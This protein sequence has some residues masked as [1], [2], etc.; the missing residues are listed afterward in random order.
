MSESREPDDGES[1]PGTAKEPEQEAP[2]GEAAPS[3]APPQSTPTTVASAKSPGRKSALRATKHTSTKKRLKLFLFGT[4]GVGKTTAAICFPRSY[5]I[6]A[7]RGCDHYEKRLAASDSELFQTNNV[8]EVVAEIKTLGSE[9]HEFRTLV[10]DPVTTLEA[11]LVEKAEKEFGAGD[12]RVWGKR[13]KT[14]RRLTNLIMG[15]D[16][17]VIVTAHGK[18]EYG[19]KMAKLGTTFDGWRRLPYMFDLVL[20]LEKR[21]KKRVAIVRKT[22]LEVEFPDGAEFDFSY[23]EISRR[24]G[25]DILARPAAPVAAASEEQVATLKELLAIVRLDEGVVDG[26]LRKAAVDAIEDMPADIIDKCIAFVRQKIT[27]TAGGA[28]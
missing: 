24:Y 16:M 22:R 6:D 17:N 10:V 2:K 13:D 3:A 11:D 8:D 25:A 9:K 15:L 12:M 14:L 19:D 4:Y 28:Q 20:E 21:G 18:I 27:K 7:E 5:V 1:K 23:E 26:W